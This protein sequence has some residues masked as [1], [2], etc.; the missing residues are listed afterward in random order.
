[1]LLRLLKTERCFPELIRL[2]RTTVEFI[3][4][5]GPTLP[6]ECE[7]LLSLLV[8]ML[9]SGAAVVDC[10]DLAAAGPLSATSS[11]S[12]SRFGSSGKLC[13][14]VYDGSRDGYRVNDA[15][16]GDS[17]DGGSVLYFIWNTQEPES[18]QGRTAHL[19]TESLLAVKSSR[20]LPVQF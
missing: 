15:G 11:L 5:L 10:Q 12:K 1:M 2:F 19:P 6:S 7:T 13:Y 3:V 20:E 18:S 17:G 9:E 16:V 14:R 8:T 4:H